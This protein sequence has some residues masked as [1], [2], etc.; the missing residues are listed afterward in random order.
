M[1]RASARPGAG[2]RPVARDHRGRH[3]R[4]PPGSGTPV[5]VT[6]GGDRDVQLLRAPSEHFVEFTSGPT[7]T[8][9]AGVPMAL[10]DAGPGPA[11]ARSP[12]VG[13]LRVRLPG[14]RH[15]AVRDDARHRPGG[16]A[17]RRRLTPTPSATPQPGASPTP[18]PPPAP[19]VQPQTSLKLT[20][21]SGQRGTRV[22][23]RV[24]VLQRRITARGD[25]DA[26]AGSASDASSARALDA[27][28]GVV[29][30]PAEREGRR[31]LRS[32]KRLDVTVPSR[33]RRR[34]DEAH[35]PSE[36]ATARLASMGCAACLPARGRSR[37]RRLRRDANGRR[38]SRA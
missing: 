24:E 18:E 3:A 14:P 33:S 25:A 10:Q 5:T 23:G 38:P 6:V 15:A 11:S 8:C 13:R 36:G 1:R 4:A 7:P 2:H 34:S 35:T 16:R 20:L 17:R 26:P 37:A 32:R 29:L 12:T 21:A 31:A 19:T 30:G 9:T 27:R 22:R 28:P